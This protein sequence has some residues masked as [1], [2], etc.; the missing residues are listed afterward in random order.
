MT[1]KLIEEISA[2]E[3]SQKCSDRVLIVPDNPQKAA[4]I[5]SKIMPPQQ[6]HIYNKS[7]YLDSMIDR[8]GQINKYL[9]ENGVTVNQ[10]SIHAINLE[11]YFLRKVGA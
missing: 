4:E 2:V 8:T 6:I 3:L 1:A 11:E 10:I 5:L 7:V 9:V